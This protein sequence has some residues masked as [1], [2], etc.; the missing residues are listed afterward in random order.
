MQIRT[1][2]DKRVLAYFGGKERTLP[3]LKAL[4]ESCGLEVTATHPAGPLLI[5][6][7]R[8]AQGAS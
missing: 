1:G 3:E 8:N 2:M 6:E 4:S 7:M 5:V